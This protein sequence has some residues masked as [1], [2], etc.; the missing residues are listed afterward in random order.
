MLRKKKEANENRKLMRF[1]YPKKI[2]KGKNTEGLRE[3]GRNRSFT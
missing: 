3:T 1:L 2:E